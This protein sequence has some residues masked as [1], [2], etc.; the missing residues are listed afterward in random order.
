MKKEFKNNTK[1]IKA[2]EGAMLPQQQPQ[3]ESA[4]EEMYE[5]GYQNVTSIDFCYSAIKLQTELTQ[6]SYLP[7]L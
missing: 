4:Q 6:E 3:L 7:H 2:Q 1:I 5:E